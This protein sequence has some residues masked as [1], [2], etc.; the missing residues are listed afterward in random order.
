M[1]ENDLGPIERP[2][3]TSLVPYA[4]LETNTLSWSSWS[5]FEFVG[6]YRKMFLYCFS[7]QPSYT[8][9]SRAMYCLQEGGVQLWFSLDFL[10][11]CSK[12]MFSSAMSSFKQVL[13]GTND[14]GQYCSAV[15]L[16]SFS[17][18]SSLLLPCLLFVLFCFFAR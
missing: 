2:F 11:L 16:T 10:Y 17:T 1:I 13:W 8:A 5:L 7:L 15:F 14:N 4:P 3:P 12:C 18:N 9:L 6:F